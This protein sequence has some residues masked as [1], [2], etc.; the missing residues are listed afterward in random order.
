[1]VHM[2]TPR[3]EHRNA[4]IKLVKEK[5]MILQVDAT[6]RLNKSD[7][8]HTVKILVEQGKF[9]LQ[10]VKV[11][12]KVGNL[13]DQ[14]LLY[15]NDVKQAEIL[16][17]EK[18]LINRPFESPLKKN[19]CYKKIEDHVEQ[20]LKL[21]VP[22]VVEDEVINNDNV[23]DIQRY[24][25]VNS[26]DLKIKE[27]KNE[28]VVTIYDVAKLH[29]V[30]NKIIKENFNN[31]KHY[32]IENEDYFILSKIEYENF[33]NEK[34]GKEYNATKEI[35]LFTEQGYL[36]IAKSITGEKAWDIQRQLVKSYFKVKEL[37][38]LKNNNLPITQQ[39]LNFDGIYDIIKMFASGITDLNDRVKML[40]NTMEGFKKVMTG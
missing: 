22:E 36:L 12:G 3:S 21:I 16:E 17:Y 8:K 18:E 25:K 20:E 28:R 13:T 23:I 10:K 33:V 40:E 14:Y 38:E 30:N 6:K 4:I 5:R 15:S 24:V 2:P 37:K 34:L 39:D 35:I 32:L 1:M 31:N 11:R 27:Y 7:I 19:H 29:E 26:N 9:K